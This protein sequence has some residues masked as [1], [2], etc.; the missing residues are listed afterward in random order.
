[1]PIHNPRSMEGV[2]DFARRRTRIERHVGPSVVDDLATRMIERYPWL[3]DDEDRLAA[4][5]A[6][7]RLR[8]SAS[9]ALGR[10]QLDVRVVRR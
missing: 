4:L 5:V 7:A 8:A 10:E 1:L 3:E 2:T 9:A 6:Q